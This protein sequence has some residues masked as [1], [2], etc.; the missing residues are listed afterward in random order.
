MVTQES[1]AKKG[2]GTSLETIFWRN[3]DR[4]A[5]QPA[6]IDRED[7][8]RHV[9]EVLGIDHLASEDFVD[10]F[11]AGGGLELALRRLADLAAAVVQSTRKRLQVYEFELDRFEYV[12]LEEDDK[13]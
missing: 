12:V 6:L 11:F 9:E 10:R 1:A 5:D 3:A 8:A 13:V 2:G 4:W 7:F